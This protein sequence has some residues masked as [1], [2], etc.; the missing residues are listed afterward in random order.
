M[1]VAGGGNTLVLQ[2]IL[3]GE[4]WVGSGQSNMELPLSSTHDAEKEIKAAQFFQIR[5]FTVGRTPAATP[6]ED[7][8]GSWQVCTPETVKD[9][10]A[11]AYYFGKNL[12]QALQTPVG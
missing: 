6:Q 1:T 3:V 4:V 12:H 5:L 8:Q 9:F 11:V 7:V 10:S 2:D